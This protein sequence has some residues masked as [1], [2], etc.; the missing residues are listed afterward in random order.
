MYM[1]LY[2]HE[3]AMHSQGETGISLRN[4][5]KREIVDKPG[6]ESHN[7]SNTSRIKPHTATR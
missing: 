4:K 3:D 1:I 7:K 2:N 5:Q 6:H